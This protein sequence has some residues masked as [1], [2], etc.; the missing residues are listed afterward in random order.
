VSHLISDPNRIHVV[1]CDSEIGDLKWVNRSNC[2]RHAPVLYPFKDPSC[3]E[4]F[5]KREAHLN[6]PAFE[7]AIALAAEYS[8]SEQM[9]QRRSHIMKCLMM[10]ALGRKKK[11]E[12]NKS[13]AEHRQNILEEKEARAAR[14]RPK[15]HSTE[16]SARSHKKQTQQSVSAKPPRCDEKAGDAAT[17][18]GLPSCTSRASSN[19][20]LIG[21]APEA[22]K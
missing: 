12:L 7:E 3:Y 10:G 14:K 22:S 13:L 6:T 9:E 18:S 15:V 16:Q 8:Q 17:N 1:V 11:V 4:K 19:P 2:S 5:S 20:S 21:S